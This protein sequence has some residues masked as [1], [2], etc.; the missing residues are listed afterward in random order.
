MKLAA[1]IARHWPFANGSGRI[2]DQYANGVE[3]APG[4]QVAETKDGFQLNVLPDLVGRHILLTGQFD[5]SVVQVLLNHARPGDVLLDI[6]A[7]I[8]YVTCVFLQK[9][10]DSRAICV[11]PQPGIVDLLRKNTS[12]FPGRA[13]VRQFALS[14]VDGELRF[15]VDEQNRGASRVSIHGEMSVPTLKAGRLLSELARA[16]LLKIDVEEMEEPIFRSMEGELQ[17]LKPRAILF[18]DQT[19][20]AAQDGPIGSILTR[21]GYS[22][23]GIQKTLL[24]TALVPINARADCRYNDYLAKL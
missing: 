7:N 17:R 14:D 13:E 3:L 4:E 2:I 16:D 8:G 24:K 21:I 11:E 6:G 20:A 12:R 1:K 22:I 5:R 15:H 9:V 10:A 19:R 18:E 23:Y